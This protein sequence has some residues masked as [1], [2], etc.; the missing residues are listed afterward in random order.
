MIYWLF[1]KGNV[2]D[3]PVQ[4]LEIFCVFFVCFVFTHDTIVI[5]RKIVVLMPLFFPRFDYIWFFFVFVLVE[6]VMDNF[7]E[8]YQ[9][10]SY[11]ARSI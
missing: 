2:L 3:F 9:W 8:A 1:P 11:S 7:M 4:F 10:L 6:L 5:N